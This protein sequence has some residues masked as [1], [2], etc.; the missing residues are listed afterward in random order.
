MVTF[1]VNLV[2]IIVHTI[3]LIQIRL[4]SVRHGANL[5]SDTIFEA[6]GKP[7]WPF[8]ACESD[9]QRPNDCSVVPR[10]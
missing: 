8:A 7:L 9:A 6:T 4:P 2:K 5:P 3:D 10:K 1:I